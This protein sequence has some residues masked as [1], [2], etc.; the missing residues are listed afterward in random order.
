M[1]ACL[2][3]FYSISSKHKESVCCLMRYCMRMFKS[4]PDF[5]LSPSPLGFPFRLDRIKKFSTCF[6]LG[7]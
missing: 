2:Q 3:M 1:K 6:G 4:S 7:D 5:H